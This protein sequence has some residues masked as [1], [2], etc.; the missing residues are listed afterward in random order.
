M[1]CTLIDPD[2]KCLQLTRDSQLL[3]DARRLRRDNEHNQGHKGDTARVLFQLSIALAGAGRVD[4]S[5]AAEK[6]AKSY[7]QDVY[8]NVLKLSPADAEKV[9]HTME[10]YNMMVGLDYR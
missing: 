10:N 7:R 8:V 2:V 5:T 6:Q 9:P 4:E 1:P 3:N